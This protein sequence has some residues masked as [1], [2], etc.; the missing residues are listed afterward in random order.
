[1]IIKLNTRLRRG[2]RLTL[3][4]VTVLLGV[5]VVFAHGAVAGGHMAPAAGGHAM[6]IGDHE[7]PAGNAESGSDPGASLMSM[8]L[9]IAQAAALALGAL[10]LAAAV[11]AQLPRLPAPPWSGGSAVLAPAA[12]L[13]R[14]ARPPDLAVLQVSR[15]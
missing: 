9:A 10:A 4:L 2:R 3:L 6:V 15:R 8:C 7:M 1:M 12:A 14:R 11:A 5:S 13:M